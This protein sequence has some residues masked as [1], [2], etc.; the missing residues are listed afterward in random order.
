MVS[1]LPLIQAEHLQAVLGAWRSREPETLAMYPRVGGVR[2]HPVLLSAQ[3]VSG[4]LA[5]PVEQGVRDWLRLQPTSAVAAWDSDDHA[6]V[7]DVDTPEDWARV[8][9]L[10]GLS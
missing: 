4:V 10:S 1:D 8:Q 6:Y 9:D 7:Q 2:G 3:A 5:L